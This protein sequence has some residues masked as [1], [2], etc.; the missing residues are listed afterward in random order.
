MNS[1]ITDGEILKC[2]KSLKYNKACGNDEIINEYI[3]TTSNMFMPLYNFF[4]NLILET[5]ILPDT[6]SWLEGMIKPIY[7]HKDN[8]PQP[9]NYRSS[10][11]LITFYS[12][13]KLTKFLMIM[14]F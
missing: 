2:I 7:K 10:T 4:F 5:G 6:K 3:K 14:I 9:E 11:I 8:P 12:S 13:A 1:P